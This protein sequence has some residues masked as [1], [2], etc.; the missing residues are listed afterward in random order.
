MLFFLILDLSNWK[1]SAI[2]QFRFS[3]Y[4]NYSVIGQD[5]FFQNAARC[6]NDPEILAS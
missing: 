1:P 4:N 5:T 6:T 3:I 2:L